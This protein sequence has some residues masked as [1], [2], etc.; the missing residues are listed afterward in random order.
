[1]WAGTF[2]VPRMGPRRD[3]AG[4]LEAGSYDPH[5]YPSWCVVGESI[6]GVRGL[7]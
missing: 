4:V 5:F 3:T 6:R 2:A 7:G 1:M